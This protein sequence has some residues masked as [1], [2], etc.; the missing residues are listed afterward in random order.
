MERTRPQ[1]RDSREPRQRKNQSSTPK[2]RWKSGEKYL[3]ETTGGPLGPQQGE[4]NTTR[5]AHLPS[6]LPLLGGGGE[7]KGSQ[8]KAGEREKRGLEGK[9]ERIKKKK[10]TCLEWEKK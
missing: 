4:T 6:R 10:K 7:A 8:I 2:S 5:Q 9:T 1:P 3:N